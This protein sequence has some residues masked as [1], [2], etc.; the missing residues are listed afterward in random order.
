[1]NLQQNAFILL[2][3]AVSAAFVGL[4]QDFL[5]PLFWAATI[6]AVFHPLFSSLSDRLKGRGNTA[7]LLT[8]LIICITVIFPFGFV[9]GVFAEQAAGLYTRIDSGELDPA[10]WLDW[11]R[12]YLPAV[13]E[14]LDKAGVSADELRQ[15]L[16]AAAVKGSQ[17]AGSLAIAAGQGAV[18]FSVMFVLMLYVLF[19]FLRDGKRILDML[20]QALPLGDDRVRAL[21]TKFGEVSRATLKGTLV[22]GIIQGT[23]G[24]IIFAL[25]GI[26]GAVFW[27]CVMVVLSVIPMVGAALIWVPAAI[28]LAVHGQLVSALVLTVFGIGVIGMVDNVLRPILV[29]RDTRMPD[30]LVL[31]STLG[32]LS[33]F[34]ASGFVIGPVIAALF[35]TCWGMFALEFNDEDQGESRD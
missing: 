19:F 28:Y 24:G 17:F 15:W 18:R 33:V 8:L 13:L 23:L 3:A 30:Y 7:A 12:T 21:L 5:M 14:L 6:A 34:G 29:G 35:L 11:I 9:A 20:V 25:L 1:M 22:I 31:L 10:E 32:G 27:G 16:S 26:D 2:L 4:L